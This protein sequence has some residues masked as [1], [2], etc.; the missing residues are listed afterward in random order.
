MTDYGQILER[1]NL[2]EL[3]SLL[4]EGMDLSDSGN[5]RDLRSYAQRIQEAETP[6]YELL[7]SLIPNGDELDN[8]VIL[9][10][11]ALCSTR[12][13]YMELG[14]RMGARLMAELLRSG[15]RPA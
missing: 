1:A 2:Q 5:T 3:R 10:S 8:A 7:E 6:A 9:F 14:L 13:V 4:L 11:G 15:E 12:D